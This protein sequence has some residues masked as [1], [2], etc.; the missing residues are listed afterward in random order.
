MSLFSFDAFKSGA[1]QLPPDKRG[2]LVLSLLKGLV[3]AVQYINDRFKDYREGK[4]ATAWA[5]GTTYASGDIV[6]YGYSIYESTVS[7]NI[8]NTP[9]PASAFWY[10][11]QQSFI[12]AQERILYSSSLK[13]FEYALN[14]Q[15]GG[16]FR[17]LPSLPDIYIQTNSRFMPSFYVGL[18]SDRSSVVGTNVSH[19]MVG[20]A[21]I[22][23]STAKNFTI[24]VPSA[25]L[26]T[27]AGEPQSIKNFVDLYN[28]I[29]LNYDIQSY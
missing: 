15:F 3:S 20:L 1:N 17:Q 11:R 28:T 12:G 14:K 9:S 4:T 29:G 6:K 8:G 19:G 16:T 22:A 26:A 10:L 23:Y 24:Y 5:I 7:G 25:L 27:I 18:T 2:N 13:L 21:S